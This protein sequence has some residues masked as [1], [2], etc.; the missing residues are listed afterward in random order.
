MAARQATGLEIAVNGR[1]HRVDA[2]PETPLL[3]VLRN[4]LGLSSPKFGCG[5]AQCGSCKVLVDGQAVPS[6]T[7]PVGEAV[8]KQ[9][10]TL[11]GLGGAEGLHPLQQAFLDE[12]AAQCG[13]CIPGMIVAAAALLTQDP[14]PDETA[15]REALKGN[16][17]RCGAHVR[18]VRAIERV[19]RTET[20]VT[21]HRSQVSSRK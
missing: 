6:C 11:E 3:Y 12:Q 8:G 17:C 10:V 21:G 7:Y 19:A 9:V 20:Q 5:L 2:A 1:R 15:I 13:V 14:H 18:I 16:L 4:D